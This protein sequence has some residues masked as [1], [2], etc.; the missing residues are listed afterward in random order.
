ML[1]GAPY[2]ASVGMDGKVHISADGDDK[3]LY[4]P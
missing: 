1:D 2:T 3:F 4:P